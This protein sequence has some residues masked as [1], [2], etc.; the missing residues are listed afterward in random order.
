M[1]GF[2]S[3]SAA[4]NGSRTHDE[5]CESGEMELTDEPAA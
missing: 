1:C 2:S 5:L 4:I 3:R